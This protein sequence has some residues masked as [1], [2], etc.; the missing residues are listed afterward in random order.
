ME[1]IGPYQFVKFLSAGPSGRVFEC[2]NINTGEAVSCK[3]IDIANIK[4]D[5]FFTHFKNELIIHSQIRHPG[6]T[7]LKDVLVDK[8]NV[9]V[10]LERCEGGDLNDL[11][12]DEGGLPESRARHYFKHIM[13]AISY[14]HNL[15]IA[16]RDIKLE[17]ILV[18]SQDCAKLTDFGLCKQA[19]TDSPMM[20]TTCGTLVYS[21]PEIIKEEPY[22]GMI[23][24]IWSAGVVLY[25][26]VSNH[27]PWVSD[28][29]LP[30]DRMV[31]ETARQITEG[32]IQL[33]NVTYELQDL[34]GCMLTVD[35][36]DRPTAEDILQHPWME[37]DE[38]VIEG[39]AVDP[40]Q[41]LVQLVKGV[42]VDLEKRRSNDQDDS[43]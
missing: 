38:D 12:L 6:I 35:P 3:V 9:Y 14:I 34:I 31:A 33:P 23:A 19:S 11:V 39:A 37:M 32:D 42:I 1:Q 15:G 16:H 24:D 43:D 40:D 20:K 22:N 29:N 26:M 7:Q 18:T 13:G 41:Q 5:D 25:A 8:K 10:I 36:A 2:H 30:P 28:P 4:S 27:F 21:A 17:N